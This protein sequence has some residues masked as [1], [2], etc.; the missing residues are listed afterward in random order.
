[1]NQH[2]YHRRT[3]ASGHARTYQAGIGLVQV[4]LILLL[5]GSALGAGA[6]LLQAKRAPQQ[7]LTQEQTLRW[8]DESVAAFAAANA[9]LPC[10]AATMDGPEDC[11]S[12]RAKGWVPTQSLI[13]GSG[14]GPRVGPVAYMAYRGAA[15]ESLDLVATSN[16]YQP[17]TLEGGIREIAVKD[18]DDGRPFAAINGLDLCRQL[19]LADI[20]GADTYRANVQFPGGHKRNVAYAIQAAGPTSGV[21]VVGAFV[22]GNSLTMDAPSRDSDAG[23]DARVRARTFNGLGQALG[24]RMLESQVAST[25]SA[26]ASPA[27]ASNSGLQSPYNVSVASMDVLAASVTL[28][29]TLAELRDDNVEA[30]DSATISAIG[31]QATAIIAVFRSV[32]TISDSVTTLTTATA[33]LARSVATCIA[34][35]GIMC[36]E[37]P[38]KATSV[39]LAV[40]SLITN[41]VSLGIKV[42]ALPPTALA[43]ARTIEARDRARKAN[44]P[45]ATDTRSAADEMAC[46]LYGVDPPD[47]PYNPCSMEGEAIYIEN[48]DYK[49]GETDP[50]LKYIPDYV[51]DDDGNRIP[52]RD[53]QGNIV[54][55]S[56][57]NVRYKLNYDKSKAPKGL[58]EKRQLAYDNWQDLQ[59]N[60]DLLQ[61][62][63]LVHWSD[64]NLKYRI[65]VAKTKPLHNGRYVY[66]T[67]D[68]VGAGKGNYTLDG[69]NCKHVGADAQGVLLGDRESREHYREALAISDAAAR[70]RQAELWTVADLREREIDEEVKQLQ[71]NYDAWFKGDNAILRSMEKERDD[72]NNCGADPSN[73]ITRQKCENARSAIN[74]VKTC[75]KKQVNKATNAVTEVYETQPEANCMPL[76]QQRIDATKAEKGDSAQRRTNAAKAYSQLP[77]PFITYPAGNGWFTHAIEIVYDADENPIDYVWKQSTAK[78][79]GQTIPYYA[80]EAYPVDLTK[81]LGRSADILVTSKLELG[82]GNNCKPASFLGL[83][84]LNT[85]NG[86]MQKG[87]YCQRYPYNRAY[88]DWLRASKAAEHANK[89]YTDLDNQFNALITQYR[90]LRCPQLK[91]DSAE[92]KALECT[93]TAQ[94][95]VSTRPFGFGAE[96][97]LERADNRGTVGPM[98]VRVH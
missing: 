58:D 84:G 80:P 52:E 87:M 5:V 15:S 54:H 86:A 14:T 37:V 63:R 85:L 96:S 35:L 66:Y 92:Y 19:E 77:S 3:D 74:Y 17:T 1:M 73:E 62:E 34:S 49:E 33:D 41:A 6:L 39:G 32:G 97:A 46:T 60:V 65:D 2:P 10:P 25:A 56:N 70:R 44:R 53:S 48:P 50:K 13:E 61:S 42:A 69:A 90:K 18:S 43:L 71:S 98:P 59:K 20:A 11:S 57:G 88:A 94:G 64:V 79:N 47:I 55:D 23:Y 51:L 82:S 93:K 72:K 38:L 36:W 95:D 76:M 45:P 67:C 4:M 9:R 81:P 31:A 29:D 75:W 16:A 26:A 30:A 21:D 22:A 7:T 89:S 78:W 8:V 68:H 91:E 28:H 24:C 40:G 83:L 27:I 12:N